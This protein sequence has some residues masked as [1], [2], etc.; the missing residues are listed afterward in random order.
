[1][2]RHPAL[3]ELRDELL[4]G[5][6]GV[7]AGLDLYHTFLLSRMGMLPHK[8]KGILGAWEA[9]RGAARAAA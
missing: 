7:L 4:G 2:E 8:E 1:M 3:R 5:F 6:A 9:Q